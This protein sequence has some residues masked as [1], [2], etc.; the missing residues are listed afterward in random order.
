MTTEHTCGG[1]Y[2][3]TCEACRER[4]DL[5]ERIE[6]AHCEDR[7]YVTTRVPVCTA[8]NAS[9][10]TYTDP[11]PDCNRDYGRTTLERLEPSR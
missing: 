11:C 10:V 4:L 7:G 1:L 8:G 3:L 9:H 6:C 5:A 2:D